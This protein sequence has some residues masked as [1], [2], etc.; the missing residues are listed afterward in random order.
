MVKSVNEEYVAFNQTGVVSEKQK[1]KLIKMEQVDT[2][3]DLL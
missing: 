2:L 1:D 3:L